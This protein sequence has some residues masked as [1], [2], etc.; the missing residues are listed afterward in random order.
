MLA[1]ESTPLPCG[2]PVIQDRSLTLI[3]ARLIIILASRG[4]VASDGTM[5]IFDVRAVRTCALTTVHFVAAVW[6]SVHLS[7]SGQNKSPRQQW[8]GTT[9]RHKASPGQFL[10]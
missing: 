1:D 9:V 2:P 7:F 10:I 4:L 8:L 5:T 6:A 3:F